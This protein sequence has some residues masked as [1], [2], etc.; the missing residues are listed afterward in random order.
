[1][2]DV[3]AHNETGLH[4][5]A[6][7]HPE[8]IDRLGLVTLL[9]SIYFFQV[10]GLTIDKGALP[11][12]IHGSMM[13]LS[14]LGVLLPR[15]W[16]VLLLNACAFAAAYLMASPIASNNQ[17]TAF[18][19]AL[20]VL[21]AFAFSRGPD[22]DARFR[23][24]AGAGRWLLPVMYFFG[25]YHKI[26]ADFLD[27]AVSCAVV[28]YRAL[29]E[30]SILEGWRLGQWGAIYATFVIEAVAMVALFIPR[31]KLFG[32]LIGVPFHV[33][34]GFTGYSYYKDF[35][36]IVLVLY[37]LFLPRE[38]FT[39]AVEGTARVA[40]G[41][42]RAL[43]AGRMALVAL[44]VAY[45]LTSG[46]LADVF[47]A[48]PTDRGFMPFFGVYALAF[49]GF[50]VLFMPRDG[51][52]RAPCSP[53]G[54]YILPILFLLNGFSPYL[55]LKTESSIAMFSNL[56]TEG[57]E[58]NHLLTGVLPGGF[59]YQSDLVRPTGSNEPRFD[60]AFVARGLW[61]TRWE[62]DRLRSLT[63]GLMVTYQTADGSAFS[64]EGEANSY[65]AAGW[66]ARK[67]LIFKPVD[68]ARPKA[69]TH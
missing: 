30:G 7:W 27:P 59:G 28:L 1:M 45:V 36:T 58:T 44:V 2:T 50:A 55:G 26:N 17:T 62:L 3:R 12:P 24:I 61:L 60:A 37:A 23:A 16:P 66:L 48:V 69:C 43:W 19:F 9:S 64:S 42:G 33:I 52:S 40:G 32:V 46:V 57:G 65:L 20:V 5:L 67:F 31:L 15:L 35:S 41:L 18:F 34:I 4:R 56:H 11:P 21:G 10:W 25:I 39:G 14:V 29:F 68:F 51:G 53:A 54:L 22:R 38:V 8:P 6:I 49:Y 13:A 47:A 63:P